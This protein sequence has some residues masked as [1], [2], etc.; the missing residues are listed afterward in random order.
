[1][2]RILLAL[3]IAT[4]PLPALAAKDKTV[5][6][7]CTKDLATGEYRYN[8]AGWSED[9]IIDVKR[10]KETRRDARTAYGTCTIFLKYQPAD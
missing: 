10:F 2:K 5:T 1:M 4:L 9:Y 8:S 3:A 6:E 7:P